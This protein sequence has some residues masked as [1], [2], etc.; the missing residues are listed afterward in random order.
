MVGS[1]IELSNKE[2]SLGVSEE[3]DGIC[4]WLFLNIDKSLE[5]KE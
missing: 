2:I 4:I 5:F 3:R 1:G